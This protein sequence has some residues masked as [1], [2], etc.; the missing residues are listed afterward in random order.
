LAKEVCLELLWQHRVP[1]TTLVRYESLLTVEVHIIFI[2]LVAVFILAYQGTQ[3]DIILPGK[4]VKVIPLFHI[5]HCIVMKI[6]TCYFTYLKSL[7][8]VPE[9]P[10]FVLIILN[11]VPNLSKA[12]NFDIF[13]FCCELRK[14]LSFIH[15]IDDVQGRQ[16]DIRASLGVGVSFVSICYIK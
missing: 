4:T 7:Y 5:L 13:S 2:I 1:I 10:P 15:T 3:F 11:N 9:I 8:K 16:H 12:S 6:S 14:Q